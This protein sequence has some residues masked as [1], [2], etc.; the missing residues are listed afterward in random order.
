[1]LHQGRFS[2]TNPKKYEGDPTQIF[3]R[4]GWEL[5]VMRWLDSNPFVKVWSSEELVIPY[6]CKTDGKRHRYFIDFKITFQDERVFI[7]E[8]KPKS[9]YEPPKKTAN[10]REKTFLNEVLTYAKNTSKWEAAQV[11]AE[12]HG[13][14]FRVWT[15]DEMK[16]L[17]IKIIVP[18]KKQPFRVKNARNR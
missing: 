3:Y 16:R 18:L 1:M 2:P 12:K 13:Y 6:K 10:K 17:G 8:L 15:E 5:S 9:Q 14:I 11:Y 7:V 4:S